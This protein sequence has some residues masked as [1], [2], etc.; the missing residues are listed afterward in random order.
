[1]ETS[2]ANTAAIS[3][4]SSQSESTAQVQQSA[5]E[6]ASKHRKQRADKGKPRGP[7]KESEPE[8][9][10]PLA[11]NDP[12]FQLNIELV[13]KSVAALVGTCDAIV[14]RRI[15]NKAIGLGCQ[16]G[17]AVEY[18]QAATL[19]KD[20]AQIISECSAAIMARSEFLVRHAPEV[21]LGCVVISYGVR[22]TT[23]MT[24]LSAL[25]DQIKAKALKAQKGISPLE[26]SAQQ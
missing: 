21:M 19:S 17:L 16:E 20:E 26:P 22:V 10:T 25:E 11:P 3:G 13:K 15:R 4:E 8:A 7:R 2:S 18:A 12:L 14:F 9:T 1:M 23:T 24:R 5:T 6:L